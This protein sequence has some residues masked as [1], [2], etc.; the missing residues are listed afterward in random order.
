MP[1]SSTLN[2]VLACSN[3]RWRSNSV[4][5]S[6][7]CT[8][9]LSVTLGSRF[10]GGCLRWRSPHEFWKRRLHEQRKDELTKLQVEE[11]TYS[12]PLP[13]DAAGHKRNSFVVPVYHSLMRCRYWSNLNRLHI[14]SRPQIHHS[15]SHPVLRSLSL[16]VYRRIH[17]CY[18]TISFF[19]NFVF[20]FL[21]LFVFHASCST[22]ERHRERETD[23]ETHTHT[24][25]HTHREKQ[26]EQKEV[27]NK[28]M[29]WRKQAVECVNACVT[30]G[31]CLT[32]LHLYAS[33]VT[34]PTLQCQL[35]L[36][37]KLGQCC[38][39]GFGTLVFDLFVLWAKF[40]VL[41]TEG[42]KGG[43]LVSRNISQS[44]YDVKGG[45]PEKLIE[46]IFEVYGPG[47]YLLHYTLIAE[48]VHPFC[49]LGICIRGK[50][51]K[52]FMFYVFLDCF[53]EGCC[54][55]TR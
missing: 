21:K 22:R 33:V 2:C 4:H 38:R 7:L 55:V 14:L 26:C 54:L 29:L 42:L 25:T 18:T 36:L 9:L 41:L 16:L 43:I 28:R 5:C 6:C 31:V 20:F 46:W 51:G 19:Y 15:Q 17:R 49:S 3:L 24:H 23:R 45:L 13:V 27:K 50:R 32:C 30:R 39:W 11:A 44:T 12:L 52:S 53:W 10:P 37:T 34:V 1:I 35:L 48:P 40:L 47:N 8:V